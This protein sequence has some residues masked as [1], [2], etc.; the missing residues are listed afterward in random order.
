MTRADLKHCGKIPDA[1]EELILHHIIDNIL[2]LS[3]SIAC[4]KLFGINLKE[5]K[6]AVHCSMIMAYYPPTIICKRRYFVVTNS[7]SNYIGLV[8]YDG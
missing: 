6:K 8:H 5:R 4:H 2:P 3:S 1:R 7:F